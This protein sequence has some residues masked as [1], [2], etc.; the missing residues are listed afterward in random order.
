MGLNPVSCLFLHFCI[1]FR[2]YRIDQP[3]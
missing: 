2:I 1:C 3:H